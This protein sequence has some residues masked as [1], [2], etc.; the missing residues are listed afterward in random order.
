MW[1]LIIYLSL[2]PAPPADVPFAYEHREAHRNFKSEK[3][4]VTAL[5]N[6]GAGV[7]ELSETEGNDRWFA[8]DAECVAAEPP[9][10]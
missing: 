4:C 6:F 2:I 10:A 8:V 1:T 7:S 5:R 9:I 3:E